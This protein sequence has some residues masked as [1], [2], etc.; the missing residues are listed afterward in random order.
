METQTVSSRARWRTLAG[1]LAAV[2]VVGALATLLIRNANHGHAGA[3][4]SATQTSTVIPPT[5]SGSDSNPGS[6]LQPSQFPVV[7]ASNPQIVYRIVNNVPQRSADGGKTYRSLPFHQSDITDIRDSWL[8]VSPLDASHVFVT[9]VGLRGN[10]QCLPQTSASAPGASASSAPIVGVALSGIVP[11]G[12]QFYSADGGQTWSRLNLP[13]NDTFGWLGESR[14]IAAANN[15]ASEVVFQGQAA[16]LYATVGYAAQDGMFSDGGYGRLYTSNDD[17]ATW[18][19]ADQSI[20]N[21]GFTICDFA[22]APAGSTVYALAAPTREGC[23]VYGNHVGSAPSSM[24]L[25]RSDNAGQSW[26]RV[27]AMPSAVDGGMAVAAGGALYIYNPVEQSSGSVSN[28]EQY[29]L[30]SLDKGATFH[31]A[32]SAGLPADSVLENPVATLSDG[33]VVYEYEVG[34]SSSIASWKP[35]QSAWQPIA[36]SGSYAIA[37]VVATPASGGDT[38]SVIDW[39]GEIHTLQVTG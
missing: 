26:T 23:I 18:G 5:P 14:A 15:D 34:G 10:Q 22:A 20:K 31:A 7:A 16:R 28:S 9:L 4:V 11:C 21:A 36:L 38:L 33:S 3:T 24:S 27:R 6:Q 19:P 13:T 2:L 8:T 17:G 37:A 25:Y 32:P 29:A 12:D 30:A 35:G 1:T 39:N